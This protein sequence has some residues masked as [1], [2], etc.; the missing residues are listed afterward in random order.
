MEASTEIVEA[1]RDGEVLPPLPSLEQEALE[2]SQ[3]F[4]E[5]QRLSKRRERLVQ[6]T[7]RTDKK[8]EDLR[9]ELGLKLVGLRQR[10]EAGEAGDEATLAWWEWF[11]ANI[12]F[13][14][15]YAERWMRIAASE[16]PEAAALE[17]RE[18]AAAHQ[19]AY[20][21][22]LTFPSQAKSEREKLTKRLPSYIPQDIKAVAAAED[23][24][25]DAKIN[26]MI[27]EVKGWPRRQ[28]VR[29]VE[30]MLRAYPLPRRR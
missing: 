22:R 13:S 19:R 1:A 21:E 7:E 5:G 17:Y 11:E 23:A 30:E 20:E 6:H 4:A 18:R 28:H 8:L 12:K 16:A 29:C 24:V 26:R 27:D 3:M 10:V 15:K 14:R 2:C 9:I 25:A